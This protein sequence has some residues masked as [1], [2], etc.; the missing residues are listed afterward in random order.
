MFVRYL[1]GGISHLEQFP[2]AKSNDEDTAAHDDSD[3]EVEMDDFIIPGDTED[4][5]DSEDDDNSGD[6]EDRDDGEGEDDED[7]ED[8]DLD[9]G[10]SSDE[11]TGNVY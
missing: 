10:E 2:P 7:E 5:E 4:G 3:S 9:P 11:D 1:G 8:D 6:N